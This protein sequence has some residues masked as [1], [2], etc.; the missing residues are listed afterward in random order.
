MNARHRRSLLRLAA[1]MLW[2]GADSV[3]EL[4]LFRVAR[5]TIET[6][7]PHVQ[8]AL[9]GEVVPLAAPTLYHDPNAYLGSV[10]EASEPTQVPLRSRL[11]G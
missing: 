5:T 6:G 7:R 2:S 11:V 10:G 8:A 9:D 3:S 1:R 4:E